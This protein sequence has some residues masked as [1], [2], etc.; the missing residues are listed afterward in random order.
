MGTRGHG[1]ARCWPLDSS[2]EDEEQLGH[3]DRIYFRSAQPCPSLHYAF[4]I[5]FNAG[6]AL[7]RFPPSA[8]IYTLQDH[9]LQTSLSML[10]L[11]ALESVLAGSPGLWHSSS[12]D[13]FTVYAWRYAKHQFPLPPSVYAP[14]SALDIAAHHAGSLPIYAPVI[15][16]PR[17][18]TFS[19]CYPFY[20]ITSMHL[21][22]LLQLTRLDYTTFQNHGHISSSH[23][24]TILPQ[25][26]PRI[27]PGHSTFNVLKLD[28]SSSLQMFT[29]FY[30]YIMST[31]RCGRV[32]FSSFSFPSY[33]RFIVI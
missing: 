3:G 30:V 2:S 27:F 31:R 16:M 13:N 21:S 26:G 1:L 8:I 7:L 14:S 33:P 24:I 10:V 9:R 17:H 15:L 4:A 18:F 29:L 5:V 19:A 22:T 11:Q 12:S 23:S 20:R 32:C 6:V 28:V 25:F